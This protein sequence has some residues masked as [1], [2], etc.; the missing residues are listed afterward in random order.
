MIHR[1]VDCHTHVVPENFP[2]YA[3]S[4]PDVPWPSMA[5]AHACHRHVVIAG[6]NY[7]TVSDGAWS[8]A[9]RI[10]GMGAMRVGRQALS[11][12][13]ELLSYWLPA[14]DAQVLL[15]YINDTIAGMIAAA[16]DRFVG[17]GA[18]PLQDMD[19]ALRELEYV[20]NTLGFAGVEIASHVNGVSIGDARF[21]AFFAACERMGAAIFVHALRPA[22]QDRIVGALSEQAVAFPGDIG[23]AAAAVI[24]G[25]VAARHPRLRIAFSHGGGALSVM[26]P[27]LAH[28]WKMTPRALEHMPEAPEVYARRFFY[29]CVVFD[30]LLVKL[31]IERY[32]A[33]QI[34]VGSDYPF[35]MGEGDPVGLLERSELDAPTLEAITATNA[36]RFLGI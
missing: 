35:A 33:S 16:P 20:R 27:R 19:L 21:D 18:V 17:L 23:L 5:P 12:M 24:T 3:G 14:D 1:C 2:A 8:V 7:R 30:P 26:L 36:T 11:P 9:R 4:N 10:E 28:A 34:L 15:R 13:P 31:L 32:G 29:D 6:K 22:G 25:G